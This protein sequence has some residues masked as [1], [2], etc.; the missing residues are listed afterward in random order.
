MLLIVDNTLLHL[1]MFCVQSSFRYYFVIFLGVLWHVLEKQES[2]T[3]AQVQQSPAPVQ[4][5]DTSAREP[6]EGTVFWV[7]FV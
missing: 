3:S 4:S 1:I 2:S 5:A 7:S 6:G